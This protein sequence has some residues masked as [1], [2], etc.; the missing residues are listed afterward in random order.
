MHVECMRNCVSCLPCTCRALH[1]LLGIHGL[2]ALYTSYAVQVIDAAVDSSRYFAL[3]IENAQTRQHLFI[4]IGF[5]DRE[6]AGQLKLT[7]SRARQVPGAA[8]PRSR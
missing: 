4:G 3:R 5:S 6:T 7:L 2:S 1:E 8:A